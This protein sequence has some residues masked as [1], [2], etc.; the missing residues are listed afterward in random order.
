MEFTSSLPGGRWTDRPDHVHPLLALIGRRVN[1][2]SSEA[3]RM[4]LLPWAAWLAGTAQ[5]DTAG[6]AATLAEGA[7]AHA[8]RYADAASARRI[9]ARTSGLDRPWRRARLIRLAVDV[10]ARTDRPDA[11]LHSML[12]D[13][14]NTVRTHAGQPTVTV[15]VEGHPSWPQTQVCEVELRIPDGSDSA[16]YHCAALP[17]RWPAALSLAWSA[18]SSELA[19]AVPATRSL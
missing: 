17:N 16:Y 1:D 3:A 11:A 9:S 14:V 13:A 4:A 19:H 6:L 12:A 7:G 18:R 2:R 8:L 5:N 10:V 15:D